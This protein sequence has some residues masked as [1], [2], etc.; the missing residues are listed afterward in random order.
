[1]L[2]AHR[3]VESVAPGSGFSV[4]RLDAPAKR[5]DVEASVTVRAADTSAALTVARSLFDRALPTGIFTQLVAEPLR[6]DHLATYW[7]TAAPS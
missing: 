4:E 6:A 7:A 3:W 5:G 2:A 1:M